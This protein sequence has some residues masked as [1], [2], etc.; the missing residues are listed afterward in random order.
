MTVKE[1]RIKLEELE[2]C[3]FEDFKIEIPWYYTD[4]Q[5]ADEVVV[6]EETKTILILWFLLGPY[7]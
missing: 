2:T 7:C 4:V 5:D 6:R 1:L 3:G